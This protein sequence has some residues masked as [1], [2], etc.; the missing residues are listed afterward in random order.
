MQNKSIK[1]YVFAVLSAVIYGSMPLMSKYIYAD[2]VNPFTLVFLR[3]AFSLIPLALLA[4]REHKTLKIP[5]KLLPSI[6]LIGVLGCSVTPILLFSSYQFIKCCL[7]NHIIYHSKTFR[8]RGYRTFHI[9][10][11]FAR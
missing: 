8:C 5:A 4:Y 11:C 2:G 3:N 10:F 9:I 6:A 1:G 7:L